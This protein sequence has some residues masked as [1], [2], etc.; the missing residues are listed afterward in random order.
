MAN[1][2][3]FIRHSIAISPALKARLE[4]YAG[5]KELTI[6]DICRMG[7]TYY[8][9]MVIEKEMPKPKVPVKPYDPMFD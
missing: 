2:R 9:A 6:S 7:L 4:Q 8:E 3:D 5:L 1:K